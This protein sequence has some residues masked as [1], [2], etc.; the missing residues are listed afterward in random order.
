MCGLGINRLNIQA[1]ADDIV[2]FCP[3]TSGLQRMLDHLSAAF[4]EHDL[5]NNV[6]KTKIMKFR[7]HQIPSLRRLN[8]RI[9]GYFNQEVLNNKYL[10][11]M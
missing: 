11:I 7:G 9:N 10:G 4:D 3:T 2:L 1:Y 5:K 6:E 8:F